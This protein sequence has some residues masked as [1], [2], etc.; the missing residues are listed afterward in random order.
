MSERVDKLH[1][2]MSEMSL[3][4]LLLVA[5]QAVN[6]GM[7]DDRVDLILKYVE[8]AITRRQIKR[9]KEEPEL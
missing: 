8:N 3:G 1:K 9:S 2:E 5:G 4:D 6:F 7:S